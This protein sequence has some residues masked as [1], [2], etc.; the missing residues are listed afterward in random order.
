LSNNNTADGFNALLT[1]TGSNNIALG[2]NAGRNLTTGDN[3]IDIG[4]SG[5][6]DESNTIRIGR[7]VH[8]ATHI[9]GIY[10]T[11]LAGGVG[12]VVNSQGRL[13]II[14]SSARFK[15][16]IKP[17]DKASISQSTDSSFAWMHTAPENDSSSR[18]MIC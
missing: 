14:Q 13:G 15:D 12:V 18:P 3:N 2:F 5:V 16:G 17:M 10:G 6:A 1:S 4:A 7:A 8:K 9:A 11:V